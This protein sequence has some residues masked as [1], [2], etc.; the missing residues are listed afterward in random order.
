M[1]LLTWLALAATGI[2]GVALTVTDQ[3]GRTLDIRVLSVTGNSV[4]FTRQSDAKEYT[5]P[6]SQ[7]DQ[8]SQE[9]I[10]KEAAQLPAATPAD[11][12]QAPAAAPKIQA[13]VV[14]GKRRRDK[15]DSYYMVKQ[16]VTCTVKIA[17]LSTT[18]RVEGLSGQIL[19]IGKNTKNPDLYSVLSTQKFEATVE[20]SATFTKEMEAFSTSYDSDNKGTGNIGGYQYFGYVLALMDG[21]GKVVLDQTTTGSFKLALGNKPGLLEEVLKYPKGKALTDKLEPSLISGN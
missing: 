2:C 16:E 20:P 4:T 13:D 19:F 3:K 9:L 14:I 18:A 15:G 10:R 11:A 17:N 8:N 7:F 1:M 21:S 12:K 5:L 6:I